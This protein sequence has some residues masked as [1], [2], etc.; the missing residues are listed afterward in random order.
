MNIYDQSGVGL[1][2]QDP[3]YTQDDIGRLGWAGALSDIA[4][5]WSGSGSRGH[6]VSMP[7][8]ARKMR[9]QQIRQGKLDQRQTEQ[10]AIQARV[11]ESQ[12]AKNYGNIDLGGLEPIGAP[13]KLENGNLGVVVED[14]QNPQGFRVVDTGTAFRHEPSLA[15][16]LMHQEKLLE[17]KRTDKYIDV[18]NDSELAYNSANNGLTGLYRVQALMDEGVKTGT[19]TASFAPH[20]WKD[21]QMQEFISLSNEA[22]LKESEK[23]SGVLSESDMKFLKES[24]ISVENKPETNANILNRKIGILEKAKAEGRR[25]YDHFRGGGN[26]FDW[27]PV[28]TQLE[29]DQKPSSTPAEPKSLDTLLKEAGI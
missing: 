10:D 23:L 25:K 3:V 9:E 6:A 19:L 12:I 11:W 1:Y 28:W 24:T 21:A 18:M 4:G 20:I 5:I 17:M 16:E 13:Q 27:S 2:S 15:E 29:G 7:M 14:K 22:V 26:F 8:Q